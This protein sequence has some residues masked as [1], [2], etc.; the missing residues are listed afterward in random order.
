MRVGPAAYASRLT[1]LCFSG[2]K[3]RYGVAR[4][5]WFESKTC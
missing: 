4:K 2:I 3:I 1:N 5:E